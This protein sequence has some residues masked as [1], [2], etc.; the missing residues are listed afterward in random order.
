MAG[1]IANP[2]VLKFYGSRFVSALLSVSLSEGIPVSMMEA[3]SF[4]VP[5]VAVGVCGI[6]EI[7]NE[8]T[9]VL[10]PEEATVAEIG[11]GL[12]LALD[13]GRFDRAQIRSFFAKHY[14]A[15][16]NYNAFVDVLMA[17]KHPAPVSP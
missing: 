13:R 16:V 4:G 9:G 1:H 5:V 3:M 17:L 8:E 2:D 14:E 7:V 10:L 6:P 15:R 12:T 11:A